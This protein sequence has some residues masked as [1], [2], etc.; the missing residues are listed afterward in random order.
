MVP[1]SKTS[2]SAAIQRRVSK[3]EPQKAI[4][5]VGGFSLKSEPLYCA[6]KGP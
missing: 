3:I 5:R 4:F 6:T 1:K 2:M